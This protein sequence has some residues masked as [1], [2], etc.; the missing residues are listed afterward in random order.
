MG[1]NRI[2]IYLYFKFKK[3]DGKEEEISFSKG[4]KILVL[5]PHVDDETIGLGGSLLKYSRKDTPLSLV[6]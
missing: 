5:A 6:Y 4:E 1:V 3:G 2:F